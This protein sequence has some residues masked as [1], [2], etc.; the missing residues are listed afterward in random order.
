M[1]AQPPRRGRTRKRARASP[2]SDAIPSSIETDSVK[3]EVNNEVQVISRSKLTATAAT[4]KPGRSY[5]VGEYLANASCVV[6]AES[7]WHQ[8]ACVVCGG[9]GQ[10]SSAAQWAC[11]VSQVRPQ[12]VGREPRAHGKDSEDDEGRR[13]CCRDHDLAKSD[14]QEEPSW[15]QR[16]PNGFFR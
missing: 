9:N 2:S 13:L 8:I 1:S 6:L 16:L 14:W 5:R 11:N 4:Q 10:G 15:R 12:S 7:G 3:C